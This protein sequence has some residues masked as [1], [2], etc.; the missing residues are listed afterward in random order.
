MTTSFEGL[1]VGRTLAD[2]YEI[3]EVIGR[4]GMSVVYRGVD[5]KLGRPV[6][7]KVIALP[8]ESSD[9]RL[10]LRERFRREAAAAAR[11][12][13]H[14]NVVQIYDYG[15][16]AELGLDFLVMELLVGRTLKEALAG[17]PPTPREASRIL[18]DA[19]RGLSAGHRAGIVHRDV[20]PANVLLSGDGEIE[21]V[22]LLDFGIAKPL[23]AAPGDD[24][25]RTG[26][27]AYSPAYASPEQLRGERQV[28]PASDVYQL[29]LV[30][31]EMLAG[32]RPFDDAARARLMRGE[33][34]PVPARG[35]WDTV[36]AEL[37]RVVE[38]ALATDPAERYPDASKMAEALA[39][40]AAAA[41][42][43]RPAAG[44]PEP[45]E[46]AVEEPLLPGV[47]V[48]LP[49]AASRP[50][51]SLEELRRW[52][53][54]L[55]IAAVLLLV[56]LGRAAF[57]GPSGEADPGSVAA[58]STLEPG[59]RSGEGGG[60]DDDRVPEEVRE[61]IGSAVAG[62]NRT[63]VEG[64]LRE[65]LSYYASRV[66]YY[67]SRRL[68]RAGIRRDRLRDIRRYPRREVSVHDVR[69]ERL[70]PDRV[71]V[72]ARKSWRHDHPERG[73]RSGTGV[74]EYVFKRDEDDGKWYVVSEQF[75]ERTERLI[76]PGEG[77]DPDE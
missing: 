48:A 12:S 46:S 72:L 5:R 17:R 32:E 74:Q 67:N 31:Y 42:S 26:L 44:P 4:G 24:L 54:P 62:I 64:E 37:R 23:D 58:A 77:S 73:G 55:A 8:D 65:H 27:Y 43:V 76:R 22:R 69:Y 20:K 71:R 35:R 61:K 63:W 3:E 21:A 57:R 60:S 11:I 18:L 14:P 41:P 10:R 52:K 33:P 15:T 56:L 68:S 53:V 6:A 7:I 28:T 34:V 30:G 70:E 9:G 50:A 29:G 51:L 19:A 47:P 36:P 1:L 75:L 59:A 49:G 2:R 25:T 39:A 13:H 40:T 16:D 45:E 66:D 38:R